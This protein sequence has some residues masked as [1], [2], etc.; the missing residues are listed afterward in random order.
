MYS[1]VTIRGLVVTGESRVGVKEL[2]L[3]WEP[4]LEF[5]KFRKFRTS[6]DRKR[7]VSEDLQRLHVRLPEQCTTLKYVE[8]RK[9]NFD[10]K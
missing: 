5:R 6:H 3:R 10:H 4:E 1:T 8:N 7:S 9:T 2:I